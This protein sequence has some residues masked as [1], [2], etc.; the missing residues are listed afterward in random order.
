M[1]RLCSLLLMLATP[2][3]AQT[4]SGIVRVIDAD[5]IELSGPDNIRLIGIDA[6]ESD[7]TCRDGGGAVLPCGAMATDAARAAYDGRSA[8]CDVEGRDRHGRPLAV[9]HVDGVDMNAELVRAGLARIYR[10]DMRYEDRRYFEQQKEAI[11]LSRG[12]WAY[13]M[14]DPAAYRAE[15][16]AGRT[17][18]SQTVPETGCR[19]KGNI[20]GG[21]RIFHA[22]GQRDYDATV[23]RPERGER[24]FCFAAEARAA[25]WRAARR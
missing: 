8:R 23:I 20:S 17:T 6:A 1:F 18:A 16:R 3:A 5:T 22:P 10:Q 13:E 11:L 25:G 15:R 12:L 2:T 19:L 4:L 24:W 14:Q 7:Q 9:C 21:G